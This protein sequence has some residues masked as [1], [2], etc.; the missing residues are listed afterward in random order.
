[1]F[2]I[3]ICIVGT[4]YQS[5]ARITAVATVAFALTAVFGGYVSCSFV[6]VEFICEQRLIVID[7]LKLVDMLPVAI[8]AGTA[9]NIGFV[10]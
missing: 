10:A 8:I 9:A 2:T 4:M 7:P 5:R 1:M 3:F 6:V